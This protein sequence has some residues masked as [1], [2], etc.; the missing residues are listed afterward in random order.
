MDLIALRPLLPTTADAVRQITAM[1][2]PDDAAVLTYFAYGSNMSTKRLRER[3]PSAR[4]IGAGV[5]KG[6]KLCWHKLSKKDG[7]GK[8]DAAPSN[9]ADAVVYGVL[10]EINVAEKPALD[11]FEGLGFGYEEKEVDIDVQG[12]LH[13]A[14]TYYAT[15][16]VP[17]LK[18]WSWYRAHVVAG[19]REHGLPMAYIEALEAAAAAEDPDRERHEREMAIVCH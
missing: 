9:D 15:T 11:R 10:F 17:S 13:R 14:S 1:N 12:Q 8:C 16:C 6:H 5:L 19:A 7:S 18:P 3:V 2:K 4:A